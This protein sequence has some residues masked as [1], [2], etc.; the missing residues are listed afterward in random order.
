MPFQAVNKI[1]I[2]GNIGNDPELRFTPKGNA[3]LKLSLANNREVKRADGETAEETH[4]YDATVWGDNA[5]NAVRFLRKGSRVFLDGELHMRSWTTKEGTKRKSAEIY[6]DQ[7]QILGPITPVKPAE[8]EALRAE[9]P[10]LA[11]VH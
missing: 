10:E 6:V 7:W 1:M 5:V 11:L 8:A 3:V 4:W 2:V 9:K